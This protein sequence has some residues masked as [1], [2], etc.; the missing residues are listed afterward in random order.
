[1]PSPHKKV[2]N[3]KCKPALQIAVENFC[4]L[5]LECYSLGNS[6]GNSI[7]AQVRMRPFVRMNGINPE[8]E[9]RQRKD[10]FTQWR[11]QSTI[12]PLHMALPWKVLGGESKLQNST[13]S[14]T[15]K[16]ITWYRWLGTQ[17]LEHFKILVHWTM[18]SIWP[19]PL[20]KKK[21]IVWVMHRT[22]EWKTLV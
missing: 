1:M 7:G 22:G 3:T 11:P 12:L 6:Q 4:S 16:Q 20:R 14:V 13:A 2:L 9:Q 15:L 18:N 5:S 17:W 21:G 19:S 8:R 10:V